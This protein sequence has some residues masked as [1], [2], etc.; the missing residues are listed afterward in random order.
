L[1]GAAEQVVAKAS[2]R[3]ASGS[4]EIIGGKTSS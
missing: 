3:I 2:A 1:I 4:L